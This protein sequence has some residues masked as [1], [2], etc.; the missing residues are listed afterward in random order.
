ME[1]DVDTFKQMVDL[2]HGALQTSTRSTGRD[3]SWQH[4]QPPQHL[5][6]D[7]TLALGASAA[8][9]LHTAHDTLA[10]S[11]HRPSASAVT[12]ASS[13]AGVARRVTQG[14]GRSPPTRERAHEEFEQDLQ[15][16]AKRHHP[17]VKDRT[18]YTRVVAADN[19]VRKAIAKVERLIDVAEHAREEATA[20]RLIDVAKHAREEAVSRQ[21]RHEDRLD[22]EHEET[23][24]DRD[25]HSGDNDDHNQGIDKEL[26]QGKWY[27]KR[28]AADHRA[29]LLEE[30]GRSTRHRKKAAETFTSTA[31]P[32]RG[33]QLL[34]PERE[35]VHCNYTVCG[36]LRLRTSE[37]SP[38]RDPEAQDITAADA[39]EGDGGRNSFRPV[40]P[41]A[42]LVDGDPLTL[43]GPAENLTKEEQKISKR[44]MAY[45]RYG[46]ARGRT[47]HVPGDGWRRTSNIAK[48][49]SLNIKELSQTIARSID[50]HGIHRF[51]W[52]G[53]VDHPDR[54]IRAT[55]PEPRAKR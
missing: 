10:P 25:S 11:G 12:V 9:Y 55:H 8:A 36:R 4:H 20:E 31:P 39:A 30:E 17:A 14:W 28:A 41:P 23:D 42:L 2:L 34:A 18:T 48:V 38:R 53:A 7:D 37:A 29:R 3:L 33:Q 22:H 46:R 26:T 45:L 27:S 50:R 16:V 15:P 44:V 43:E 49:L 24:G 32:F 51:E 19:A 54:F 1:N 40:T 47:V 35:G 5:A 13:T 6:E 52:S 21:L